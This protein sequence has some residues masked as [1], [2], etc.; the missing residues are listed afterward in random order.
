MQIRILRANQL[1]TYHKKG[2]LREPIAQNS[3]SNS[4]SN[5]KNKRSRKD[6]KKKNSFVDRIQPETRRVRIIL[7]TFVLLHPT[8]VT[9]RG[10][11]RDRTGA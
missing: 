11:G 8:F 3:L 4:Q 10:A 5:L 7:S 6:E 2:L 1:R 9:A